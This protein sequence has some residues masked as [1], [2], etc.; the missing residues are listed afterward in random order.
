MGKW[1]WADELASGRRRSKRAAADC[2]GS[3]QRMGAAAAGPNVRQQAAATRKRRGG[4]RA[5]A[6]GLTSLW[7]EEVAMPRLYHDAGS[8]DKC[9]YNFDYVSNSKTMVQVGLD[10]KGVK[11]IPLDIAHQHGKKIHECEYEV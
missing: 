4:L 7:C 5:A 3:G 9:R 10:L 6:W 1:V 8:M 2:R 11:R